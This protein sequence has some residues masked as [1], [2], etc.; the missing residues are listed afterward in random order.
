M[1]DTSDPVLGEQQTAQ[2]CANAWFRQ[3]SRLHLRNSP[4]TRRCAYICS[5]AN[6]L[7][8]PVCHFICDVFRVRLDQRFHVFVAKHPVLALASR[9]TDIP[10]Q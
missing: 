9:R 4:L 1:V 10:A 6:V 8:N 2:D 5:C 3:S 7:E